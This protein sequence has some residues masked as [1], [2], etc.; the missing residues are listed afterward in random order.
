MDI[1]SE[2]VGDRGNTS[3]GIAAELAVSVA[4]ATYAR[5]YRQHYEEPDGCLKSK[6]HLTVMLLMNADFRPAI[7]RFGAEITLPERVRQG[8]M[9]SQVR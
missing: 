2:A 5:K 4:A 9:P 1:D 8:Q 7:R 3:G 6:S